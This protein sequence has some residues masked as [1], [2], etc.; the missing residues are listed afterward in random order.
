MICPAFCW[1]V[2][3][4]QNPRISVTDGSATA[5]WYL[6]ATVLPRGGAGV[7]P[8]YGRYVD[9]Y[10]RTAQGWKISKSVLVF[11]PPPIPA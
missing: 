7:V 9:H 8:I 2:H 3:S 6:A 11:N 10:M 4:V 1:G 5:K